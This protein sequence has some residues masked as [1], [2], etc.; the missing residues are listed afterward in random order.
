MEF[1]GYVEGTPTKP[2]YKINYN[3]TMSSINPLEGFKFVKVATDDDATNGYIE[4]VVP[5]RY[6]AIIYS[7]CDA[8]TMG[9]V[10]ETPITMASQSALPDQEKVQHGMITV[11]QAV[12]SLTAGDKLVMVFV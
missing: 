8:R 4:F 3:K 6:D 7:K 2:D 10:T 9:A 1:N 11:R 5:E 12:T